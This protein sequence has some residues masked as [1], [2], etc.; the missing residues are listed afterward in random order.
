MGVDR[1]P[2]ARPDQPAL[3]AAAAWAARVGSAGNDPALVADLQAWRRADPRH[4]AAWRL[5]AEAWSLGGS[6]QA[7]PAASRRVGRRRVMFGAAAAA[8]A[9]ALVVGLDLPV[10]LRAD[11]RTG[12][13]ER[14]SVALANGRALHLNTDTAVA[15]AMGDGGTMQVELLRGELLA[16]ATDSRHPLQL[17]SPAVSAA[18][19]GGAV[20]LR[21][22][23][24]A[25]A[26]VTATA[27]RIA[28]WIQA[29][30]EAGLSLDA[31]HQ[32]DVAS[33]AF[34]AVRPV[35]PDQA[36][37]WRRG[38]LVV[39][40]WPLER[41]VAELDRYHLGRII[42]RGAAGGGRRVEGVFDI[43]DPLSAIP[44]LERAFGLT[45]TRLTRFLTILQG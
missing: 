14:R 19:A 2:G 32:V 8:T 45:A 10:A 37:A 13:G 25:D 9:T 24:D 1:P 29:P 31:G 5:A 44:V 4:E 41:L 15:V 30:S 40:D 12:I 33:G 42:L 18:A 16:E 21:L 7:A 39:Q 17:R 26:T 36:T 22:R 43:D 27:G 6:V 11:H 35:A 34:S 23:S 20:V 3:E 28:T 38:R